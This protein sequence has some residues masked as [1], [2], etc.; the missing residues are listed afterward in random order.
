MKNKELFYI[1]ILFIIKIVILTKLFG[2][3]SGLYR[4]IQKANKVM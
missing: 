4:V 3:E 2:M 1:Q